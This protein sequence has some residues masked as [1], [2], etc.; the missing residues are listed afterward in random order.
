MKQGGGE[1]AIRIRIERNNVSFR[2][3]SS[4]SRLARFAHSPGEKELRDGG[5]RGEISV[6][7]QHGRRHVADGRPHTSGVSRDHHHRPEEASI[8]LD[9]YN[10]PQQADHDNRHGQIVQNAAKNARLG[11]CDFRYCD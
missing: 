5:E 8:F 11:R 9:R 1:R 10:L 7:P 4:S 3:G 6:D 2:S